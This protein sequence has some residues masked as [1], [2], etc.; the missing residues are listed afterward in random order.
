M[1][2]EWD[3][4][5]SDDED[6]SDCNADVDI[7]PS[8]C[9]ST[10][11]LSHSIESVSD[12]VATLTTQKLIKMNRNVPL[13]QRY[14]GLPVSSKG[15]DDDDDDKSESESESDDTD[16]D[17]SGREVKDL[18]RNSVSKKIQQRD[19][20]VDE[21]LGSSPSP[22]LTNNNL[23]SAEFDCALNMRIFEQSG[24]DGGEPQP[25][26]VSQTDSST[27]TMK[28]D[29]QE[30]S[31]RR[32]LVL[33]GFLMVASIIKNEETPG[34]GNW[35]P[36]K[37]I[38]QWR[39]ETAGSSLF[40]TA[41]WDVENAE[42]VYHA[43]EI[44]T[45]IKS[46]SYSLYIVSLTKRSC[47]VNTLS[48]LWK[49]NQRK[50]PK[51]CYV[52]DDDSSDVHRY[53][54]EDLDREEKWIDFEHRILSN[55]TVPPSIHEQSMGMLTRESI[56]RAVAALQI[57]G[58]VVIPGL[59]RNTRQQTDAVRQ[60]SNA[61]L[62]DFD[63]ATAILKSK[64]D[65]DILNPG[66]SKD[67]LSY[68]EMAMRE[69][70]RVDLRDGPEMRKIRQIMEDVDKSAL[71]KLGYK[72]LDGGEGTMPV[73]IDKKDAEGNK[74]EQVGR[75]EGQRSI[76]FDPSVL[77]IVRKLQNPRMKEDAQKDSDPTA[78]PL[79]K[80]NFGRWNF[81]GSGPN[82]LPQPTRIGQIGS[83]IS[84]PGAADQC[85]HADTAHIFETHDCL[86]CH[87]ANLF[88]LGEDTGGDTE[89]STSFKTEHV[90][91]DGNF[92]GDN[93][94]GGTA[95]VASSH[96]LSMTA[97]LTAD[98][99]IS[100]AGSEESAQ[101]EMHMRTMRPSLQL[102]DAIIF[103]TRTLHFGL[104]NRNVNESI[105]STSGSRRPMLYVNLTHSW[106][107]DPKNW[108]DKQSLFCDE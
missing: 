18:I 74:I 32:K 30:S 87:Y 59:F 7:T 19:M 96:R 28:Y 108:D 81:S 69:D 37:L 55:A 38:D 12:A 51:S 10:M 82:G 44:A 63:D 89:G 106:F 67:P 33:G 53:T 58:F 95:F 2:E 11:I 97:R 8:S 91:S 102:G 29:Q 75:D 24:S 56:D 77:E 20:K 88:V 1:A 40:S 98:K 71:E 105:E 34:P 86:P 46:C 26:L 80:G 90:D 45:D 78:Q 25:Q 76:R 50:V 94:T 39:S 93:L 17:S 3:M 6:D 65:V 43:A 61:V 4:F 83:V 79:Y 49:T 31:I 47:R 73:I 22:P 5:G 104:A 60:W 99:G 101:N 27:T 15:C 103:D 68:R 100:A 62:Q 35:T 48:C 84:L 72:V 9:S 92:N 16:D 57:Y 42:M 52:H 107:F 70:M 66:E 13:N 14:V 36:K 23:E 64:F 54:S 85:I 21:A 41:V